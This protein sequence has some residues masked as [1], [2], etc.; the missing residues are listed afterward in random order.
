MGKKD[1]LLNKAKNSAA[2]LRFSDLIKLAEL[3]GFEKKRQKGS[4]VMMKHETHDLFM[5]FQDK[6]GDAKPYQVKQL[7]KDIDDY[8]L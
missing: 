5:N 2:N 3:C 6:N 7:L 8:N 1:K 4:H